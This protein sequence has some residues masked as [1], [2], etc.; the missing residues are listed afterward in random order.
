MKI[1]EVVS[2]YKIIGNVGWIGI[3]GLIVFILVIS[4]SPF[5]VGKDRP[6]FTLKNSIPGVA[7]SF[8]IAV[9]LVF[10]KA[11][12]IERKTQIRLANHVKSEFIVNGF[13]TMSFETIWQFNPALSQ[14]NFTTDEIKNLPKVFPTEFAYSVTDGLNPADTLGLQLIDPVALSK[15]D[16]FNQNNLGLIKSTI[17]NYLKIHP[18]RN[19]ISF[20]QVRDSIDMFYDDEWIELMIS[21][22]DSVFV[23]RVKVDKGVSKKQMWS[24]YS[25]NHLIFLKP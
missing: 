18:L 23:S 8:C 7:G 13:K 22:Y 4:L 25:D 19:G 16:I 6:E 9:S 21:K 1:E 15:I 12:A 24:K 20:R 3:V 5:A 2:L 10:L 17:Q 14:D 11:D